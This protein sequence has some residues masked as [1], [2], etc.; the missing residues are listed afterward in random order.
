MI[1][2]V[3]Y[4]IGNLRSAEKALQHLGADARLTTD[5]RE[6]ERA[7]AVVLPGRRRVRRVHATRCATRG[8]EA[9]DEGRGDRR[10]AVPRHLRRHADAVRRQRRVARR[11]RPRR[12][13]RAASPG[14]RTRCGS[15]RWA[16]TRSRSRPVRRL[17]RASLPDP[18]WLYFVHTFAPEPADDARR[19]RVVRV[20]AAVR[21]RGRSRARVGHAVPPREVGRRRPAAAARTSSTRPPPRWISI[22]RSTC[23]TARSCGC[24]R[25]TTTRETNY[26]DDPVAVARAVRRGRRALDPRRRSRRGARRRQPEPRGRSRRSARTSTCRVQTGGGVRSSPTRASAFAAGVDARRHRQRGGRA[27]RARRRARRTASRARSR[28]GSTRAAATS[29]STAGPTA[30]GARLVAL[31]RR[32]DRPGRR[33]AG[34]H[35][36]QPRRHARR[37]RRSSSSRRV[38]GAVAVPVIASGGVASARRPARARR[39][40][41]RRPA[42]RRARSS[43]TR[44]L[45]AAV[46]RRG[47]DRRVLAVRVIPCLDVDAGRVV[48]GVQLR[49]H[50][51]RR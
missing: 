43:G 39:A 18:A 2:V 25:A 9:R 13:R 16:G 1:A 36:H 27:A 44:D 42:A 15:R 45:R 50:P 35:R 12:R 28:S 49:R 20:R 10:P 37:A 21:G 17:V 38:L 51:R 5:A 32:F 8:L 46:H 7:D 6:I 29:R 34:R 24:N 48:K 40:R 33:R 31:A 22:P 11:R 41:G 23:A 26:D 19:R 47:R 3:D 30:T 14:C 4:G